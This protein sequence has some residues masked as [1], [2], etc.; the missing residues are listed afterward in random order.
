MLSMYKHI[1]NYPDNPGDF[2]GGGGFFW[3]R[4]FL[5]FWIFFVSV[6][7]LDFFGSRD[8]FGNRGFF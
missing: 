3:G 5:D 4:G 2:F 6:D 8:F 1:S 7:F